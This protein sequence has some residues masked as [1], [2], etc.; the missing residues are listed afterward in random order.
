MTDNAYECDSAEKL[1][2][3][4]TQIHASLGFIVRKIDIASTSLH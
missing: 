1:S 2:Q 3:F 4:L